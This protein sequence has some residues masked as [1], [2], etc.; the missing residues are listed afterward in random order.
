VSIPLSMATRKNKLTLIE[1][2]L[3][4]FL[5]AADF[6]T[7]E[8]FAGDF[9]ARVGAM[10]LSNHFLSRPKMV[11]LAGDQLAKNQR[12][13]L[14]AKSLWE[15]YHFLESFVTIDNVNNQQIIVTDKK[16]PFCFQDFVSLSNNNFCTANGER[17]EVMSLAWKVEENT[18]VITY[19][20]YRVYD[21]NLDIKFLSE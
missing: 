21:T 15:G 8:N 14:S 10:H 1:E 5:E 20:V 19:R 12:S 17:A 9:A 18:A 2:I 6:F 11:V 16:I 13:I 4:G 3:K 7:G